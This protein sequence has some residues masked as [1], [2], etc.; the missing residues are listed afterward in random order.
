MHTKTDVFG[1]IRARELSQVFNMQQLP[2][3]IYF[4]T[5][6]SKMK[7]GMIV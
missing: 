6:F 3:F 2:F 7:L 5:E 4:V 1:R